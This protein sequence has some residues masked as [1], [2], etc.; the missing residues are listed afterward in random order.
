M[1]TKN[2]FRD[3]VI[4]TV[5]SLVLLVAGE[6]L[7]R[8][9]FP[10]EVL[11]ASSYDRTV[12]QF[13]PEILVALKPNMESSFKRS[14]ENGGDLIQWSTNSLG[15]RGGE[16]RPDPD[17]RVVVYGDSNIQ[18]SFSALPDTFPS[19]LEKELQELTRRDVEVINGGVVGMGP[20]QSLLRLRRDIDA[21]EP[22]VVVFHVF[23][24]NDFGD[25][26]RNRLFDLDPSGNLVPSEHERAVDA[27]LVRAYDRTFLSTLLIVRA[28]R[29]L[30]N[31]IRPGDGEHGV[32]RIDTGE[33]LLEIVLE[34]NARQF[35]VYE[36][37]GPG[38]YSHFADQYDADVAVYPRSESA[39]AKTRLM[40]AVLR[41]ARNATHAA[42][43][44]FFVVIQPSQIDL[45][46]NSMLSYQDLGK[47]PDYRPD[48][49]SQAVE[50]ILARWRID[51]I[52]LFHAFSAQSAEQLFFKGD[53][54]H[55][56][57]AGQSLAA[58]LTAERLA[59][60]L[61]QPTP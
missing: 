43:A 26:I 48:N 4:I 34:E 52:S 53:D 35:A 55:W 61:A 15:F 11:P 33:D 6:L 8:T 37:S 40:D 57:D 50:N 44:Q 10:A 20:D 47:Y 60:L 5:V 58:K 29:R 9:I 14:K 3:G 21:L 39:T 25:L 13:D 42:G 41:E 17:V 45:T 7:L 31:A 49:L 19:R 56:N 46:T 27:H 30:W 16:L 22:D 2:N 51:G 1:R 28:A 36:S 32:G 38:Q 54:D 59:P 18:A 12:Y 24:D 23:A